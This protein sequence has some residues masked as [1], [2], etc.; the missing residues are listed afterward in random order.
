VLSGCDAVLDT[1]GGETL[2][3]SVRVLKPGGIIVSVSGPPGPEFA[4][5]WKLNA[6]LR[7]MV[8]L[9]SFGIRHRARAAGG[10]YRF[11]F[12]RASG[13]QLR[14]IAALVEQGAVRPVIDRVFGFENTREALAYAEAGHATGKVVIRGLSG[15]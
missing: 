5:E 4:R 2:A 8:G 1:V 6:P 10:G 9:M 11:F 7:L 3:R 14:T 12:M 15:P 13:E